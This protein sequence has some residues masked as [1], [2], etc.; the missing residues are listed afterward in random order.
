MLSIGRLIESGERFEIGIDTSKRILVCGKTG[1]GKSYTLGVFLEELNLNENIIS[2]VVDSQ[3]IFWT[4]CQAN[5]AENNLL[6]DWDLRP[7]SFNVNIL[8]PGDPVERYGG[9]DIIK[10]MENR[11][12]KFQ[13]LLLN[14][15]DISAEM[16][17]DLF[18]LDINEL[19]GI[20]LFKAVRNCKLKLKRDFFIE[21]MIKEIEKIRALDTTKEAV[22]RKLEMAIDWNIFERY[23]Y[24]EIWEIISPTAINILDLSTIEQARY[25]LRNL[26]V[27]VLARFIFN[28]RTI[29]R[30]R[31]ALGLSSVLPKVW[32]AVD[33]AQNFCPSGK[34]ALAKDIL[35]RWA[36]EGRQPGL[37]LVVASQQPSAVDKEIL[38]Q[39]GI[40]VIHR[41][42]A[43]D[44]RKAIN[45]LSEDYLDQV[46]DGELNN[47]TKIGEALFIDDEK[48]HAELVQVRP[49][50]SEH[51]GGSA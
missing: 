35:I 48:E 22:I 15:S 33:E 9:S 49:R 25:G 10:E 18:D 42:T 43:K 36:K 4:M 13:S 12:V 27:G 7:K 11:G 39:C 29:S 8:V 50:M 23:R 1:Y 45:A 24:K 44:D 51:G 26:V 16:W 17:C 47:V 19:M 32:L 20:L 6:W 14:P 40:K 30:R 21:D 3:G 5:E 38:T 37:S 2:I 46:L 34:S 28:Q 31:E 41:I